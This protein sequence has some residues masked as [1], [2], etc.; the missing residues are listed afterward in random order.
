MKKT[1]VLLIVLLPIAACTATQ[2]EPTSTPLPPTETSVPPTEAPPTLLPEPTNTSIPPT[3]V[4]EPIEVTFDGTGCAVTGPTEVTAG[5]Q[6][7]FFIDQSDIWGVSLWLVYFDDGKTFQDLL[8][9]QREPGVWEPKPPWVHKV[10][11]RSTKMVESKDGRIVSSTWFF[12]KVGE[13]AII[14]GGD[15]PRVLWIGAPLMVVEAPS[16]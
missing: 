10:G 15:I 13:H 2:P 12:F 4:R 6:T 8:H 16:E 7:L 11:R 9:A 5:L 3:Q 1:L 14:C